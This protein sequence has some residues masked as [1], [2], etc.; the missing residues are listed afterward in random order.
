MPRS[1]LG[2]TEP[3]RCT[4]S[5]PLSVHRLAW[6]KGGMLVRDRRLRGDRKALDGLSNE[7]GMDHDRQTEPMAN[8]TG[9]VDHFRFFIQKVLP[10]H[11]TQEKPNLPLT[12]APDVPVRL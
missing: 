12:G 10:D 7:R 2:A 5:R 6:Q 4:A 9:A 3:G 1:T 8:L 11:Q